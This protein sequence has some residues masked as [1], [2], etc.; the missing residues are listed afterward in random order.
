V[1]ELTSRYSIWIEAEQWESGELDP[2]DDNSDVM[3]TRQDGSR[4][5]ATFFTYQYIHSLV[6]SYRKTGECLGG[7]Y[8]W[9]TDLIL[10]DEISRKSIEAVI[11][12]LMET[13]D[14][15]KVFR[16]CDISG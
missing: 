5:V 1:T 4:W 14:F 12:D 15:E 10:I 11:Q 2:L 16:R 9:A 6:E 13:D 7:K 8:F 3:V